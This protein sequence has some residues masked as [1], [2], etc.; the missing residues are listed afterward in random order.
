MFIAFFYFNL[1]Y[2]HQLIK[3]L[4]SR[5]SAS[6]SYSYTHLF[7]NVPAATE[8]LQAPP[9]Q[10]SLTCGYC[11]TIFLLLC[12]QYF[13]FCLLCIRFCCTNQTLV[14]RASLTLL[15]CYYCYFCAILLLFLCEFIA[16]YCNFTFFLQLKSVVVVTGGE[17]QTT[18]ADDDDFKIPTAPL[19]N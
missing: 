9:Q 2:H 8:Q 5:R 11:L 6:L 4:E 17:R 14:T 13:L 19:S 7:E 12:S 3:D 16:Y 1:E 15:Q 18:E 10:S